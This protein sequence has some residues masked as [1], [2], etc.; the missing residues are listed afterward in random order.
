METT[1]T[2]RARLKP[3]SLVVAILLVMVLG[4]FLAMRLLTGHGLGLGLYR[5]LPLTRAVL[6][7]SNVT[8]Y[9]HGDCTN[10]IFLHHSTGANLIHP[11]RLRLLGSGLQRLG[12]DPSR[13]DGG[14]L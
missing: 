1:G 11:G 5:V 12:T 6:D 13:R 8:G 14:R 4:A 2:A 3:Y 9:N 7:R 10:V